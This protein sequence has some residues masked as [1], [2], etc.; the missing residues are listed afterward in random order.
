MLES[1]ITGTQAA[2]IEHLKSAKTLT[3]CLKV[4]FLKVGV[5]QQSSCNFHHLRQ[6]R[7]FSICAKYL[8]VLNLPQFAGNSHP[9][10]AFEDKSMVETFV[11]TSHTISSGLNTVLF[12]TCNEATGPRSI[13]H[14]LSSLA[15]Y[16]EHYV[17]PWY[18]TFE[19]YLD[20]VGSYKSWYVLAFLHHLVETGRFKKASLFYYPA[21]HCQSFSDTVFPP[22]MPSNLHE[23]D[24]FNIEEL[25]NVWIK[26][27]GIS[28]AVVIEGHEIVM[29]DSFLTSTYDI[30]HSMDDFAS[31]QFEESD[32]QVTFHVSPQP[33]ASLD[34][35]LIH[36]P[37]I[38]KSETPLPCFFTLQNSKSYYDAKKVESI[39]SHYTR[40]VKDSARWPH[41]VRQYVAN[42][43]EHRYVEEIISTVPF[44]DRFTSPL[45][46]Y[47]NDE[48]CDQS[49]SHICCVL[50]QKQKEDPVVVSR[51][52]LRLFKHPDYLTTLAEISNHLLEDDLVL[53]SDSSYTP[54]TGQSSF[55]HDPE[56]GNFFPA[57]FEYFL[58]NS[59]DGCIL[60]S[61]PAAETLESDQSTVKRS[62][63]QAEWEKTDAPLILRSRSD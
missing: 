45:E 17:D 7:P 40:Y 30:V 8:P 31:F 6:N 10:S 60:P 37:T 43:Q 13:N 2:R 46:L 57:S 20:D 52:Y 56:N 25:R 35:Q 4:H 47:E 5:L 19:L 36:R 27:T 41:F 55:S 50:S 33:L 51:A 44:F 62:L 14:F 63:E 22:R 12:H 24:I 53:P 38:R 21:G 61:S 3:Y 48:A 28:Q 34:T 16:I 54:A 26:E 58:S 1:I 11:C 42:P 9:G 15:R 32:G 59:L 49:V 29:W 23:H 39:A 18:L